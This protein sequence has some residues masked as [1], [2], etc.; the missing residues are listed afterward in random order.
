MQSLL[1]TRR[2]WAAIMT[3]VLTGWGLSA[4][5]AGAGEGSPGAL[6]A[7]KTLEGQSLELKAPKGGATVLVFYSSECPISNDYTPLLNELVQASCC[8]LNM[9]G[10]CVDP[11][12]SDDEVRNHAKE[13]KLTYPVVH[14]RAGL[15][16]ARFGA[17]V[18]PEVVVL[19][20]QGRVRYQGR[21][22]D[23]WAGRRVR[24]ETAKTHELSD[25]L[26][27]LAAGELGACTSTEA[28]GCPLPKPNLEAAPAPTYHGVVASILQRHCQECHRAGQVG[29]FSLMTYA[30]AKKRADDI[31]RVVE[32]RLMPPWKPDPHF[33][34]PFKNDKSLSEA[35]RAALIAW[36]E[37]DAPEGDPR[38]APPPAQFSDDWSLGTPDLVLKPEKVY[39]IPASGGDIYRCFVIKNPLDHDV[40]IAAVEYQPGNRRVVHH[41][42][43]YVDVNGEARK[44]AGDDPNVSYACFSGP[45]VEVFGDLGGWAP[46]NEPGFLPEGVGRRLPK[47]SDIIMQV[48]Y[49]PS[50]KAETDLTRMGLFFSKTPLKKTIHW[51]LALNQRMVLPPGKTTEIQA[52]WEVPTD[53]IAYGVTPHMH[54]LGKW[55]TM[56]L[57][58]PDGHTQ[59]LIRISNWDFNWQNS[60]YFQ[61][62]I[63]VPKGTLLK[64]VG[65]Y[66]NTE[67]NP[68]NPNKPPKEVKWG[69]ATTDEMC[70]G[71]L[72]VAKQDQDL[73]RG[74]K[75]DFLDILRKQMEEARD[76]YEQEHGRRGQPDRRSEK[77]D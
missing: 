68:R 8:A 58:F 29:P 65:F 7:W 46:G 26:A 30:Q 60:Y 74:D 33:G 69:E 31:A 59:D 66:D 21:I 50:G 34:V 56:S 64:V 16:A 22:D 41:I 43:G 62:P 44:R 77:P 72:A 13:F 76:K 4:I 49:H 17:K 25:A 73:T 32:D 63:T 35:E 61:T 67:N 52:E 27:A 5:G 18:T 48:H 28:V 45:M 37:A 24:N 11:D 39:D 9:V 14:D 12:L 47:R 20:D 75:D 53:L 71:F 23:R 70:V 1:R 40:D 10:V 19:D 55:M 36:A 51:G 54:L 3:A 42:L 6:V 2:L 15:L 38:Q 57:Q